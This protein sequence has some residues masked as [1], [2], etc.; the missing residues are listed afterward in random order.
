MPLKIGKFY[1]LSNPETPIPELDG[2]IFDTNFIGELYDWFLDSSPNPETTAGLKPILDLLRVKKMCNWQYGALERSWAWQNIHEVTAANF[3]RI[4]A[5]LF[6]RIN[7]S[8]ETLLFANESD[9][10]EWISPTRNFAI[11]FSKVKVSHP[12]A[13]VL[14]KQDAA[15]FAS[16]VTPGWISTLLLMKYLDKFNGNE[17]IDDLLQGYLEWKQSCRALGVPEMAEVSMVA[18]L[19][20]FSGTFSGTYYE[21]SYT[22]STK[23]LRPVDSA[24]LLKSA[25]WK[26]LGRA[27]VARNVAFDLHLFNYQHMMRSSVKPGE[28]SIKQ[29]RPEKMAIVTGDKAMAALNCQFGPTAPVPGRMALRVFTL[30]KDSRFALERPIEDRQLLSKF[31][32]RA[33]ED[34]PRL[35]QLMPAL[36]QLIEESRTTES[37]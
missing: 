25:K 5:T 22:G 21:N 26:D 7:Q 1:L 16:I 19:A 27:K 24:E 23:S 13:Q 33:P 37:G 29:V 10:K 17:P 32:M 35:D 6:Q 15:E 18:Q 30:P 31:P 2:Y 34:L 28:N 11:P 8:I 36:Q 12:V 14:T 20:F 3:N 9:Y 4:N